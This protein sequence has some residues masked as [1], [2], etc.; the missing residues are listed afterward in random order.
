[1][2]YGLRF[3][4]NVWGSWLMLWGLGPDE[5]V[6]SHAIVERPIKGLA[7][8]SSDLRLKEKASDFEVYG[9]WCG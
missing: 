9:V 3:G 7:F 1:M 4:I 2:A 6:E 5:I 8:R